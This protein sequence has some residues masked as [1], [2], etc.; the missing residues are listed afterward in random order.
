MVFVP[1]VHHANKLVSWVNSEGLVPFT[2]NTPENPLVN[3]QHIPL[4]ALY[5]LQQFIDTFAKDRLKI[6]ANVFLYQGN[7]D[8]VVD[9]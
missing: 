4:R 6:S 8:P 2:P 1:L 7:H 5:Q 3:Y 9:P